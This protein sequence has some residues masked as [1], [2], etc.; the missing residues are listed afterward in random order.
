MAGRTE[1]ERPTDDAQGSALRAR[2]P[3]ING[4]KPLPRQGPHPE[5]HVAPIIDRQ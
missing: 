3:H 2:V 5:E 4:G 1:H